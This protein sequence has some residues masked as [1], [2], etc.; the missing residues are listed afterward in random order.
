MIENSTDSEL[1][2]AFRDHLQQTGGY[3]TKVEAMLRNL[4]ENGVRSPAK[5][6]RNLVTEAEDGIK[7]AKDPVI[8]DHA[9]RVRSRSRTHDEIAVYGTLRNWATLL[10][11]SNDSQVLVSILEEQKAADLL[12]TSISNSVNMQAAS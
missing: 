2:T 5:A 8:R 1:A 9:N 4:I 10:G 3:V 7:D 11:L 12:L 6:I